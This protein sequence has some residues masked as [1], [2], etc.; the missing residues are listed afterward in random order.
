MTC[1]PLLP[2]RPGSVGPPPRARWLPPLRGPLLFAV[3]ARRVS[4]PGRQ[5]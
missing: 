3:S 1:Q 5:R 2:V 4:P